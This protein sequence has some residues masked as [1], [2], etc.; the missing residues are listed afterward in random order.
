MHAFTV[1]ALGAISAWIV[2]LAAVAFLPGV[3]FLAPFYGAW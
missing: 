2:A 1:V 3:L